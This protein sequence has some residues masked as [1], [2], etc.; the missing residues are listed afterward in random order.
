[1]KKQLQRGIAILTTVGL[2]CSNLAYAS[3][4]T[5]LSAGQPVALAGQ[6][7]QQD[8]LNNGNSQGGQSSAAVQGVLSESGENAGTE[9]VIPDEI[10][11]V[12]NEAGGEIVPMVNGA[13]EEDT[14]EL[15]SQ[16]QGGAMNTAGLIVSASED[17]AVL[18]PDA[19]S[20]GIL[21]D[22]ETEAELNEEGIV[23]L[24]GTDGI[25]SLPE[26]GLGSGQNVASESGQS[27]NSGIVP[28]A[29]QSANS[30]TVPDA[31]QSVDPEIVPDAV[32]SV[33]PETVPDAIQNV[34]PETVPDMV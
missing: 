32:Q 12:E 19:I 26:S 1:M 28:D 5:D 24:A 20:D 27:A 10:L 23:N 16:S 7:M 14:S 17:G 13:D 4:I 11:G 15:S 33:D 3:E 18:Q 9:S 8:L 2:L 22:D 6:S 25:L 30:G 21:P 29:E 31:V 34:D